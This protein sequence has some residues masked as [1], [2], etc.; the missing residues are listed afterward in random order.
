[1]VTASDALALLHRQHV[2]VEKL[3][4]EMEGLQVASVDDRRAGLLQDREQLKNKIIVELSR[5]AAVEELHFYPAIR[6]AL[7]DGDPLADRA[8]A[9]QHEVKELLAQLDMMSP[10]STEFDPALRRM[11]ADVREHVTFEEDVVFPALREALDERTLEDIGVKL[12]AALPGAP[13]HPH[14]ATPVTPLTV[15]AGHVMDAV[16]DKVLGRRLPG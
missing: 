12:Q 8:F 6:A 9:Q 3:F 10:D 4:L 14:P 1:M 16:R 7:A 13:T 11:M 15:K 5:H 2:E